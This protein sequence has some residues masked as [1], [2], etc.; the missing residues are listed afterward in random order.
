MPVEGGWEVRRPSGEAPWVGVSEQA[1]EVAT[2]RQLFVC[3]DYLHVVDEFG[4]EE[5]YHLEI[6]L[7]VLFRAGKIKEPS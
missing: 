2:R 5:Q 6:V 4:H 7:N 3:G 1:Y